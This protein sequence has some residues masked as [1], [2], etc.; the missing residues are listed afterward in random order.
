MLLLSVTKKSPQQFYPRT[1]KYLTLD[2]HA[3]KEQ[4]KGFCRIN[5]RPGTILFF[6][7]IPDHDF[8]PERLQT[9]VTSSQLISSR[10]VSAGIFIA[11][12]S[13]WCRFWLRFFVAKKGV[14]ADAG[15]WTKRISE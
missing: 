12:L 8:E 5:M 2:K 15:E 9:P 13:A 14:P 10:N 6:C 3:S 11:G 1:Q 4:V 7:D